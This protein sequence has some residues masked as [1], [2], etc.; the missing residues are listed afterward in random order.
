MLQDYELMLM[1]VRK[2]NNE[3]KILNNENLCT[4]IS[5]LTSTST[6]RTPQTNR[7]MINANKPIVH[8]PV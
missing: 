6:P 7:K 3:T 5:L 2:M 8:C 1:K 4:K